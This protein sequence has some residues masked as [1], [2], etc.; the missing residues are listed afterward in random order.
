MKTTTICGHLRS[1][2][3]SLERIGRGLDDATL[4]GFA[5][6]RLPS[7]SPL[8]KHL[9]HNA[10]DT[11]GRLWRVVGILP[12]RSTI[13]L[14]H[15]PDHLAVIRFYMDKN[16]ATI[17]YCGNGHQ[18]YEMANCFGDIRVSELSAAEAAEQAEDATAFAVGVISDKSVN[19]RI[20]RAS[21]ADAAAHAAAS[22]V[23]VPATV[24]AWP[25]SAAEAV[26]KAQRDTNGRLY[27]V[28]MA[29]ET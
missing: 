14:K 5:L 16:R 11:Q 17:V 9:A 13:R 12:G 18:I 19:L 2:G 23:R 29:K 10:L 4:D 26:Y 21:S 6:L 20:K 15:R 27:I 1:I 8:P 7:L 24:R 28:R 3:D 22:S 25:V